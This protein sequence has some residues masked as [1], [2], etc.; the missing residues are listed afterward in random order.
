MGRNVD[1]LLSFKKKTFYDEIVVSLF[2]RVLACNLYH[3]C[4]CP[5]YS[6]KELMLLKA[7]VTR[8]PPH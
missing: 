3:V 8:A 5:D 4:F 1:L 7:Q 6:N 2:H